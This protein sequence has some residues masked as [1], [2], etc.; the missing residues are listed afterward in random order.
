MQRWLEKRLR[1]AL[2]PQPTLIYSWWSTFTAFGAAKAVDDRGIPLVSRAH[3]YDLF[4]DQERV[5]FVPFQ[6]NLISR[7]TAVFSV[8]EAGCNY[9]LKKYP[10]YRNVI[11][12]AY[13]GT[14]PMDG[15]EQTHEGPA[16]TI[17]TCSSVVGVKRLILFVEALQLLARG[18]PKIEFHWIHIGGGPGLTELMNEC[19]ARTDLA[20]KATF[21]GQV[22]PE[23]VREFFAH[24][25]VDAFCNVSSSEGL[26]VA[27]ME[28]AS[29]GIPLLALDVGGNSEVVDDSNG[30]L[31]PADA[32]AEQ[33]AQALAGIL[34][35]SPDD[36]SAMR[37]ASRARWEERF[38]GRRNYA[39]FAQR[40]VELAQAPPA[41]AR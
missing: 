9:L 28:A 14:P 23:R 11:D 30:R 29:A 34:M 7:A 12:V 8:S 32:D 24:V 20:G 26:P 22:A 41:R 19:S 6:G 21:L 33:I 4:A 16:E 35:A 17:V 18:W 39:E 36:V 27:L 37:R 2:Q 5:G 31:L 40:L 13:L 38:D 15:G 3:G 25:S 1:S 10:G